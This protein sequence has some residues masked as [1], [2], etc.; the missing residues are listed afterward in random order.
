MKTKK[1][2]KS[3]ITVILAIIFSFG[4]SAFAFAAQTEED[5]TLELEVPEKI[6]VNYGEEVE[7]QAITGKLGYKKIK[8]TFSDE[9]MFEDKSSY[10]RDLANTLQLSNEGRSF[11]MMPVKSG[12]LTVTA[13]IVHYFPEDPYTVNGN[14]VTITK[15]IEIVVYPGVEV[16]G[17]FENVTIGYGETHTVQAEGFAL[18]EGAYLKWIANDDRIELNQSKDGT[19]CEITKTK[20]EIASLK[21][22]VVDSQGNPI[23]DKNGD[24]V[25]DELEVWTVFSS[26]GEYIS[27][28]IHEFFSA[29]LKFFEFLF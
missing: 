27:C 25:E 26:Y 6:V 19:S 5:L 23:K 16:Y 15:D 21:V 18:P 9:E 28:K 29:F 12:T 11:I 14:P 3:I 4:A 22:V 13:S 8:W 2:F 20:C 24:T 1:T 10:I 17:G 7:L